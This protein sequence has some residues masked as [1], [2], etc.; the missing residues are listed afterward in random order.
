[1][2]WRKRDEV[3]EGDGRRDGEEREWRGEGM[4]RRG[5][6]E[7]REWRGEGMERGGEGRGKGEGVLGE[8]RGVS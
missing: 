1:M 8:G 4:E 2:R 6:G 7:E 3:A 5:N